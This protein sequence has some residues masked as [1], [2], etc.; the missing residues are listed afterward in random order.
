[1]NNVPLK[2]FCVEYRRF[3]NKSTSIK[4]RQGSGTNKQGDDIK[5]TN[6]ASDDGK[7]H[8][9]FKYTG[10]VHVI[11]HSGNNQDTTDNHRG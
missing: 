8:R 2:I 4:S 1:M 5:L 6:T 9:L 3:P 7:R 10:K 11:G